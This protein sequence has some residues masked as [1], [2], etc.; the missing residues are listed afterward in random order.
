M[1][2]NTSLRMVEP[3]AMIRKH[4]SAATAG[5]IFTAFVCGVFATMVEGPWVGALMA[6]VGAI[7]GAPGAAHLAEAAEPERPV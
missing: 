5:G 3:M 7:I 1:R 4:P 2:S 6:M